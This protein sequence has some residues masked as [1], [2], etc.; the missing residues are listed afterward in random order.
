M[1][2]GTS[3]RS[4]AIAREICLR[5]NPGLSRFLTQPCEGGGG[6]SGGIGYLAFGP[7]IL[8][9]SRQRRW[10]FLRCA[11]RRSRHESIETT[12]IYVEADLAMKERALERIAPA[13][14]SVRRYRADDALLAFLASL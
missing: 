12:H 7:A 1:A 4:F 14:S 5:G 10:H 9:K 6:K 11:G 2:A 8:V 3:R 13:N